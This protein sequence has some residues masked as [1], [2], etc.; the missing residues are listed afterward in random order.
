MRICAICNFVRSRYN[1][2]SNHAIEGTDLTVPFRLGRW[3]RHAMENNLGAL[4][5]AAIG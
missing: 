5:A 4:G 2:R 1:R 3:G